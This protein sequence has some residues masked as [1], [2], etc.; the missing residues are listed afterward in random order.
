MILRKN[1]TTTIIII[2][3]III[4]IYYLYSPVYNNVINSNIGKGHIIFGEQLL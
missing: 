2:I 1:K 3:I 4:I